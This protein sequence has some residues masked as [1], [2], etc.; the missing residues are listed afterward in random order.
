M[1]RIRVASKSNPGFQ[2]RQFALSDSPGKSGIHDVLSCG[3]FIGSTARTVNFRACSTSSR[4]APM[5]KYFTVTS[6]PTP[7]PRSAASH[8][9]ITI[10]PSASSAGKN[11]DD[12]VSTAVTME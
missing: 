12:A 7:M 4:R 6:P 2:S 8:C 1:S 10:S 9:E 3:S 11:P 5:T